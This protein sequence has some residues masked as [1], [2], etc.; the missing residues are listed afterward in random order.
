[1]R[2]ALDQGCGLD[3]AL[4]Q[5]RPPLHFKQKEAVTHQCRAWTTGRLNEALSHIASAAKV[6]RLSPVLEEA[7][8]ERLLLR[9]A[10]LA[11]AEP[12]GNRART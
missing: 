2:A 6:A 4:R 7:V 3:E 12:D 5:L 8:T 9:L 10:Q 11:K 1:V